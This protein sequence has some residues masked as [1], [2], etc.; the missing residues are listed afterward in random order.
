MT[1]RRVV[2]AG[3]GD[4]GVLTAIKLA[5]HADVTGISSKP[6]LVSGQELG[7]RLA[8]PDDWA[9][10]NWIPFGRFRGLDRVRTVHGTLTGADLAGKT[11]TVEDA[12]GATTQVPYD[13]LVIA[14][15]VSNGFW[16][17]PALQTADEVG[18]DLRTPH[19]KLSA[20][21]T[22]AI[23]GGGAAAVSS[24]AQIAG[25]WPDKRVELYFPG[26]RALVG[27]HPRTWATVQGRLTDAGVQLRPG[28]RAELAPGFTADELTTGPVRWSTGQ[29]AASA[30]AVL[31]AIG[32]V[33]PN[34]DWLPGEVLDGNGFVIVTPELRLPGYPD[35]FAVGDVAATD[36]LRSSARNRADG[37]LAHN[38]RAAFA[39]KPLRAYRAPKSRWGSVLGIQ[40]DGLEVF[41]PNGSAFRFPAW[42]FERVLMP[43]IVRWGI[44]RGVRQQN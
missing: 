38:I 43:F 40:P 16:R 20:A 10:H 21:K 22:V 11:V 5:K 42:T 4:V 24:A 34:T 26:D 37:L 32:K 28:Y 1:G 29:P 33:R 7:W 12:D 36:P 9:R 8:R 35:V 13:A 3:L 31:W 30:D 14:T 39:G 19:E 17:R 23:I 18:A 44:Y 27:H 25:V 15:G 6:G 41:A 2:I